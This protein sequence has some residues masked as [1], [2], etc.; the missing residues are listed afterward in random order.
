MPEPFLRTYCCA[1]AVLCVNPFFEK[2]LV[3][4]RC[5]SCNSVFR[6]N[7]V[8]PALFLLQISV[9]KKQFSACAVSF[10]NIFS[11]KHC[12]TCAALSC[13]KSAIR[14]SPV[15]PAPFL[16]KFL[17][18][19][20]TH[21]PAPFPNKSV[22]RQHI[23]VPGSFL[24]VAEPFFEKT[25]LCLCCFVFD[26]FCS[27]VFRM[28][29]VVPAPSFLQIRFSYRFCCSCAALLQIR[30]SAKILMCVRRFV[31]QIRFSGKYCCAC[32]FS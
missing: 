6:E 19:E 29:T 8:V 12:C 28:N 2:I 5:S 1:C 14:D 11:R 9:L 31:L 20:Y 16:C 30:C 26:W 24:F 15:V 32:I 18:R 10:A 3:C 21:V 22:F 13:C 25:L 23:V 4:L 17:S 7:T 27:A